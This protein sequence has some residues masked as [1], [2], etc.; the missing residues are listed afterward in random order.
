MTRKVSVST[1]ASIYTLAARPST[2]LAAI[3]NGKSVT[4]TMNGKPVARLVPLSWDA[5]PPAPP[6]AKYNEFDVNRHAHS[7][8]APGVTSEVTSEQTGAEPDDY[9]TDALAESWAAFEA[10]ANGKH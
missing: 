10:A 6:H 7:L 3:E 9:D 8:P 5:P 4:V 2:V 1:H